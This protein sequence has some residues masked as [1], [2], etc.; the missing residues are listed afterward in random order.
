MSKQNNLTDFLT[1]V[2]NA[3]RAKKGSTDLINPQNFS[4]E[5]ASLSGGL[6]IVDMT[7]TTAT[8]EPNKVYVWGMVERLNI[9]LGASTDESDFFAF[10]F[11]CSKPT[12]TSLTV[13]GATWADDTELDATGKPILDLGSYYQCEIKGGT[14]ALYARLMH[15]IHFADSNVE[16]VLLANGVGDG[17]GVTYKDAADVTSI[18]TWFKDNADITAFS[19]FV[20][21]SGIS[22]LVQYAFQ[23]CS[24]LTEIALPA[25]LTS[26][27]QY[28]FLNCSLLKRA[29]NFE[30]TQ[31]TSIK[32]GL[33]K[34]CSSLAE[35]A[36]PSGVTS[37]EKGSFDGC[38]ALTEITLPASLTSIGENAFYQCSAL[39]KILNL[40]NTQVTEIGISAFQGCTKLTSA[41]INL[42]KIKTFSKRC[43][44]NTSLDGDLALP[45]AEGDI[46]NLAFA[47][48]AISTISDLGNIT[49]ISK[50]IS[51][52]SS[53]GAFRQCSNLKSVILPD[54][55]T[56]IGQEAFNGCS[57]LESINFVNTIE[58]IEQYAFSGCKNLKIDNLSLPNLKSLGNGAFGFCEKLINV[59][60]LG[61]I[62][63]IPATNG[64]SSSKTF[65]YCK[66]LKKVKI[67]QTVTTLGTTDTPFF[68]CN[69]LEQ[70]IIYAETPPSCGANAMFDTTSLKAIYVPDGCVTAYQEATVWAN[71]ASY[72]KPLSEF[73]E[74]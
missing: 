60:D 25:S 57:K 70:V 67:P 34:G 51:W 9:T 50:Y 58:I 73:V 15:Y 8:I 33:F 27:G 37:I 14:S 1:D 72:I 47:N 18:S 28:T 31:L 21:F 24:S 30:N 59:E 29:V 65:V 32:E 63:T 71:Y 55:L 16:S 35:I 49:S 23:N 69:A 62:T 40:E 10:R 7:E 20:N 54:T 22:G 48:T 45:S 66:G 26:I 2:A 36:L 4:S 46:G 39:I 64:N 19:E 6:E 42:S 56:T 68:G 11:R 17:L 53:L 61:S 74:S 12:M 52:Y 13:N 5:I 41:G 44:W 38:S 43:F 3:I